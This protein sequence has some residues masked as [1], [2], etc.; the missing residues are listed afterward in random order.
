MLFIFM[1]ALG[2][3]GT[4]VGP[5]IGAFLVTFLE[6]M[7]SVYTD[8]WVIVL[9]GVYVITAMYAPEGILGLLR[10]FRK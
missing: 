5:C 1:V 3:P 10:G 8:R 4:L 9:G 2:G 7:V 6:N